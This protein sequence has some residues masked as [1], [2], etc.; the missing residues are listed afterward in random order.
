MSLN[1]DSN[2]QAQSSSRVNL[3]QDVNLHYFEMILAKHFASTISFSNIQSIIRQG[4]LRLWRYCLRPTD[5]ASFHQKLD[6]IKRSTALAIAGVISG[7]SRENYFE[8][9]VQKLYTIGVSTENYLV[10]IKF[11]VTNLR[12]TFSK[13]YENLFYLNQLK[14]LKTLPLYIPN[15]I[16]LKTFFPSV[17]PE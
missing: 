15:I 4:Q 8:N 10:F 3:R 16:T 6:S 17:M 7:T 11:L 2:E 12:N 13:K 9:Q 5:N 1:P 14:M